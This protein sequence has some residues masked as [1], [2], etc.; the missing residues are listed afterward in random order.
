MESVLGK[1]ENYFVINLLR[2]LR[3]FLL[4]VVGVPSFACRLMFSGTYARAQVSKS[5]YLLFYRNH[6][7]SVM[8]TRMVCAKYSLKYKLYQNLRQL[9]FIREYR[10]IFELTKP[11]NKY[12]PVAQ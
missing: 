10:D 1:A 8:L 12:L 4:A 7:A 5:I 9:K 2:I 6:C 3:L 11:L